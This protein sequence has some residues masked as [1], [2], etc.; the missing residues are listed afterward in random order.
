MYMRNRYLN[1]GVISP[2]YS[3]KLLAQGH[4]KIHDD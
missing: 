2:R 4:S 3:S 1:L